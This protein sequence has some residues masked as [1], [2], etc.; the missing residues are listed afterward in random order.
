MVT[1][2]NATTLAQ[3]MQKKLIDIF[4]KIGRT[5]IIVTKTTQ[6]VN[7]MGRLK[8]TSAGTST[9]IVG[10]FQYVIVKDKQ[11]IDL[12]MAKLGDGVCYA[13]ND[14]DIEEM[15]D[16]EVGGVHW[17]ATRQV[18][19]ETINGNTIYQAWICVKRE[20]D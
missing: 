10:D 12:G 14:A 20:E 6:T 7:A 4:D 5:D 1:S 3:L 8:T 19:G 18:E 2:R 13:K 17:E 11:W 9:T 15:D 16:I